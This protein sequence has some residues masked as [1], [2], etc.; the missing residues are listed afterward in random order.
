MDS[1]KALQQSFN[2]TLLGLIIGWGGFSTIIPN[3]LAAT[4]EIVDLGS[5]RSLRISSIIFFLSPTLIFLSYWWFRGAYLY[6]KYLLVKPSTH[7]NKKVRIRQYKVE[8]F[9]YPNYR[10]FLILWILLN[11]VPIV[12]FVR[13]EFSLH[14]SGFEPW[15]NRISNTIY[16]YTFLGCGA[17]IYH[18]GIIYPGKRNDDPRLIKAH[19][20]VFSLHLVIGICM[21]AF[22]EPWMIYNAKYMW[23][24]GIAFLIYLS[25]ALFCYHFASSNKEIPIFRRLG[26]CLVMIGFGIGSFPMVN[27]EGLWPIV[28]SVL[29]LC[30]VLVY[31]IVRRKKTK[32]IGGVVSLALG[33][34]LV[35]IVL[36]LTQY[37]V[38]ERIARKINY[39]YYESRYEAHQ[40]VTKN[41]LYPFFFVL[42]DRTRIEGLKEPL[43]ENN[44]V[45]TTGFKL[46]SAIEEN[47]HR[48]SSYLKGT[49]M[50]SSFATVVIDEQSIRLDSLIAGRNGA[51]KENHEV[52][53][54]DSLS[55]RH[56]F[57]QDY[58]KKKLTQKSQTAINEFYEGVYRHIE[59]NFIKTHLASMHPDSLK[60]YQ[61]F[62]HP[63]NY[64]TNTLKH[65][66][67]EM[68]SSQKA[69]K[70]L[71]E[72][73]YV[74]SIQFINDELTY[75][76]DTIKKKLNKHLSGITE[77]KAAEL[78]TKNAA[79]K[80][81][82][83]FNE[84]LGKDK[85][86]RP[87]ARP[88]IKYLASLKAQQYQERFQR[89]QVIFRSYLVDSQRIGLFAFLFTIL[90]IIMLYWL[91][92][93]N[94]KSNCDGF[95]KC[96]E[97]E[98]PGGFLNISLIV[99]VVLIVHIA[100]P[101]E[102]ENINPENPYWMMDIANW[103]KKNPVLDLFSADDG[104]NHTNGTPYHFDKLIDE[105]KT[106]NEKLLDGIVRNDRELQ[107]L[108]GK[109]LEEIKQ[110]Q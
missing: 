96:S 109:Q 35:T 103:Y 22:I 104:P 32:D 9:I 98:L 15:L 29:G 65:Y 92:K 31:L 94:D 10:N 34:A 26:F 86:G 55:V 77:W 1:K 60:K 61:D 73:Q 81:D 90:V 66:K 49:V 43:I 76:L 6:Q 110:K 74:D 70:Y 42:D 36:G 40:K 51:N 4:G 8:N 23:H 11:V 67:K 39:Q 16:Y 106:S 91:H 20:L 17:L 52:A 102:P 33:L 58:M 80:L 108:T 5:F 14:G 63:I 72:Y 83:L 47:S 46:A 97:E 79:S 12:W 88:R 57:Y 107:E 78:Q 3:I 62:F 99:M 84:M 19:I 45:T 41:K 7:R 89:A 100:R 69:L 82:E 48:L 95:E 59:D 64:Y 44:K 18:C 30:G 53:N 56:V 101:I 25:V 75:K 85:N 27:Y 87:V 105:I 28:L 21:A 38:I 13:D 71:R 37:N 2:Q 24:L 50:D 68:Q 54:W 93:V